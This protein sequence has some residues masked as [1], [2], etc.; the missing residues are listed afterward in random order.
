MEASRTI[1]SLTSGGVHTTTCSGTVRFQ[2]SLDLAGKATWG[3]GQTGPAFVHGGRVCC[4]NSWHSSAQRLSRRRQHP[5]TA[6][7]TTL[8]PKWGRLQASGSGVECGQAALAFSKDDVSRAAVLPP[9]EPL[10]DQAQAYVFESVAFIIKATAR[11]LLKT[12]PRV[13]NH[14]LPIVS[15]NLKLEFTLEV[16]GM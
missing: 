12:E 7:A 10:A 14:G 8:S 6:F 4:G 9:D 2:A 11:Q 13:E 3:S 5:E 1:I 15:V 16:Q